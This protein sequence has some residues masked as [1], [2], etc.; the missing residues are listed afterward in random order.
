MRGE[1]LQELLGSGGG[2]AYLD[3][4][5]AEDAHARVRGTEIDTNSGSHGCGGS[6]SCVKMLLIC[7]K[8]VQRTERGSGQGSGGGGLCE[9]EWEVNFSAGAAGAGLFKWRRGKAAGFVGRLAGVGGAEG[10]G[11]RNSNEPVATRSCWK[12]RCRPRVAGI[13]ES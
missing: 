1:A 8:G 5:V 2:G 9:Y 13:P 11:S 10:E 4:I 6:L 12:Y 7:W 3:A